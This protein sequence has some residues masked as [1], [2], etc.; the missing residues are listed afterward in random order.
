MYPLALSASIV[1]HRRRKATGKG[2][3]N[4]RMLCQ[5]RTLTQ[6]EEV[7]ERGDRGSA[8]FGSTTGGQLAGPLPPAHFFPSLRPAELCGAFHSDGPPLLSLPGVVGL[9]RERERED[10]ASLYLLS[11][12]NGGEENLK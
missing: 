12:V 11:I 2:A 5:H 10:T 9:T 3:R 7:R 8:G 4:R 6:R 1:T